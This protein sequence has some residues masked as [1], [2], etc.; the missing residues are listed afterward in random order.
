MGPYFMSTVKILIAGSFVTLCAPAVAAEKLNDF[1][2]FNGY[3][4]LINTPNAEVLDTGTIDVGFNNQLDLRG[5]QYIDG[6]NYI[7]SAGL[8][9]GFEVSG[10]IAAESMNDNLFYSEGGG[11]L[12]DLSFNAKYKIPLIPEDWFSVAI[13]AKDIGGAANNYETYYAVASKQLWDFRFS[14][15]IAQS[16]RLT[17]QMDGAFA[18]VEWQVFDW[19]SLQA[20][21]DAEATNAAARITVPKE[22][23]YDVGS[24]TFTSRFYSSSDFDEQSSYWGVNFSMPL[25]TKSNYKPIESAPTPNVQADDDLAYFE[26]RAVKE[27]VNIKNPNTHRFFESDK[28]MTRQAVTL[29]RALVDDGFENV[30]V[31]YNAEKQVVVKFENSVF[32]RNDLDAIGL[33]LGRI[34]ES[35]T[36]KGVDFSVMMSK[37]DVLLLSLGGNVDDYRTFLSS[38]SEPNIVVYQGAMPMPRAISW[39]G[40]TSK[41]SPY[42]KPRVTLSPALT[43]GYATELGVYDFSL[44]LRADVDIPLWKGAG[45]NLGGQ[46]H[47]ADSDDFEKD[48][49]FKFYREESAFDRATLYQTFALP[50]GVYNQTQI[51]Y[52]KERHDFTGIQNETTWL[53][54]AGRHKISAN[55]GYFDYQ[56]FDGH[57]DF[58]TLSYQYNWFEQDVSLHAEAGKYWADDSGAKVESR[59]WF[60]DS[61]LAIY[62]EDTSAQK[63]GFAF[64]IP[65]SPR[66]DMAV[67]SYGQ[68]RGSEAWR[69]SISSQI[70]QSH[71]QLV[72]NQGRTITNSISLDRK[73]LNQG[74]LS[75][76]YIYTNFSRLRE[77]YLEYK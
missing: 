44:A 33:V 37:Q 20:E 15:G 61:Y 8:F 26:L 3:T 51:G 19:F 24:L 56:D 58:Q 45:I 59:F 32:N 27:P 5:Q 39:V 55:I 71:N 21:H 67:T 72:F 46:V 40:L 14:A 65:L 23:L 6:Y 49:P 18:G 30:L 62:L 48:A 7:F 52:F 28:N 75:S 29:K 13:G 68:V 22:W 54:P 74:R 10:Q 50:F 12:R 64:S 31:G 16:E 42:F 38:D 43:N 69:H 57:K 47:I 25:F 17:G 53:S 70:S 9:D 77:A 1:R 66:K 34:A 4:G 41:N 35:I 76:D 2:S 63:I 73:Y 60:G 11:Q 36:S